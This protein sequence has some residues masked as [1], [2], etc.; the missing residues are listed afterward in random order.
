M[1]TIKYMCHEGKHICVYYEGPKLAKFVWL[2]IKLTESLLYVAFES[3]FYT[4]VINLPRVNGHHEST[5]DTPQYNSF[6]VSTYVIQTLTLTSIKKKN[7]PC[8][9][10]HIFSNPPNPMSTNKIPP[11][12]TTLSATKY[13]L[14]NKCHLRPLMWGCQ[15][16]EN[17]AV[18]PNRQSTLKDE[19]VETRQI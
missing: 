2:A 8:P 13:S 5:S 7:Y 17:R 3:P 10:E 14:L 15:R 9:L 12:L 1:F 4:L 18:V 6:N 16:L 19:L 11:S